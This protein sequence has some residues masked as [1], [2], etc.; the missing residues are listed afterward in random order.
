[1]E[2]EQLPDDML[3]N[4]LGRLPPSILAVSRC[5]PSS[6]PDACCAP[7][8]SLSVSKLSS[9]TATSYLRTRSSLHAPLAA[10]RIP[11]GHLD[12][13]DDDDASPV[14]KDHCNGLLLHYQMVVNPATRQWATWPPIPQ[15]LDGLSMSYNLCVS[16][17]YDPMMSSNH[18]EVFLIPLLPPGCNCN[19]DDRS[20]LQQEWPPS[21]Y[22]A[23][24]FSS[25]TKECRWEERS[26]V[27]QGG[28]AAGTIANM[29]HIESRSERKCVYFRRSLY[30]HCLNDSVMRYVVLCYVTIVTLMPACMH[31]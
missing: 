20:I 16:L 12:F 7:T 29:T 27:H 8:S 19:D 21:P 24:V 17:V 1:M 13:F 25:S 3:A 31:D 14:A 18:Y 30:V 22:T 26:F 9:A 15:H 5:V 10:R 11:G 6:T 28:E 4:I 2:L 23:Y